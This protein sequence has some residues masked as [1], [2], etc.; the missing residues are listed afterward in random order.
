MKG[1]VKFKTG[2]YLS[3]ADAFTRY[4]SLRPKNVLVLNNLALCHQKTGKYKDAKTALEKA[5]KIDKV[6]V[7]SYLN[8]MSI[9][10]SE[11]DYDTT[12]RIFDETQKLELG[13][14]CNIIAAAA[15]K[16]MGKIGEAK[17]LL[18]SYLVS[19]QSDLGALNNLGNIEREEE[20]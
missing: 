3:A 12:I 2:A 7:N 20:T 9:T 1:L 5:I 19:H 14:K 8:L 10:F 15:Y 16:A 6:Y 4:L 18:K 17:D 11:K 13:L